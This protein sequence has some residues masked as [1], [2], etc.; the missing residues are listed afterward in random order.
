MRRFPVNQHTPRLGMEQPALLRHVGS[1]ALRVAVARMRKSPCQPASPRNASNSPRRPPLSYGTADRPGSRSPEIT[2]P[3]HR[4]AG[5][6]KPDARY[7]SRRGPRARDSRSR[8]LHPTANPSRQGSRDFAGE[9]RWCVARRPTRGPAVQDCAN[10]G[11]D[12]PETPGG[13][14]APQPGRRATTTAWTS[15]RGA[16][17]LPGWRHKWRTTQFPEA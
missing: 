7:F 12:G 4:L 1:T 17:P 5:V 15:M 11:L 8:L 16:E 10:P 3:A 14:G 13:W 9:V 6:R 2:L